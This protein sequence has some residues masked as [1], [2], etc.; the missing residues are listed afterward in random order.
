[1][2]VLAALAACGSGENTSSSA[3]GGGGQT[4]S[5]HGS[6]AAPG[7]C[8]EDADCTSKKPCEA[9]VCGSDGSC[10]TKPLDMGTT[11][12]A[13]QQEVGDCATA[14][15]G[16]D[17]EVAS[18]V[19]LAD[20]PDDGNDCT[21]DV[22]TGDG[23]SNPAVAAGTTCNTSDGK[24]CNAAGQCV[25]CLG[26]DDCGDT[27]ACSAPTCSRNECQANYTMAGTKL[28]GQVPGDCSA[29]VCDGMGST[30]EVIDD[31]D[32]PIDTDLTD[33]TVPYCTNGTKLEGAAVHNSPC[34]DSDGK[35]CSTSCCTAN[36][37]CLNKMMC[38]GPT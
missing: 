22:C 18:S 2:T 38:I 35:C 9:A 19:D 28:S 27:T 17:G 4:A 10:T 13:Y 37:G 20:L 14:V 16:S 23:P 21:D 15:C 7:V 25:E 3:N 30:D 34:G 24:I 8:T 29:T 26:D 36:Q 12:P 31:T 6:G 11:L 32:V 5:T 33:C 1:V